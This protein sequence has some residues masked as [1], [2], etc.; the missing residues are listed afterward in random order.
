MSPTGS[1][2]KPV[3]HL[4]DLSVLGSLSEG[5]L[6]AVV[7]DDE[8][9]RYTTMRTIRAFGFRAE[10]Y[11]S[12]SRFLDSAR[13]SDVACLVLDL[14]MP[15][16]SGLDLQNHLN[17][18]NNRI[19]IIFVT[20]HATEAEEQQALERGAIALLRKPLTGQALISAIETALRRSRQ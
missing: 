4:P 9:A 17:S 12:A 14:R 7:D 11:P 1:D 13:G 6:I 20:A 2:L 18:A 8:P 16:I 5:P 15:D 19:P 3:Q 10:S